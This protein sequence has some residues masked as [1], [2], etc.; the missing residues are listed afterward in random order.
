[1]SSNKMQQWF[2][3]TEAPVIVNAPMAGAVSPELA[4]E[5]SKAGGLGF[6]GCIADVSENSQQ[7]TKLDVDLIKVR[8]LLSS[9]PSSSSS[10]ATTP[11]GHLRIGVGFLTCHP[12]IAHFAATALPIVKK[13]RPAAVWLFAPHERIRPQ[14]EIV[15]LLKGLGTAEGG[16]APRVFVQVGNVAAAREA[17]ADGADAVVCQGTDA[18]GHQFRRGMGVV[19]L[20]GETRRL[21]DEGGYEDVCVLAAGGIADGKGVAAMMTLEADAVVLGTRFTV[22]QE[23]IVPDFRKQIIL[24]ASDGALSTLKSPFN[25]D[26]ADSD[27]WGSLYDGRAVVG[28]I[29]EKFLAGASLDECRRELH[30]EHSPEEA[31]RLIDTWAGAGIGLVRK[32]QPAGEI[33]RELREEAKEAIRKVAARVWA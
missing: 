22:A 6:L 23:S 29:H 28:P 24:E 7:V 4:A 30:E 11:S 18:G 20:L 9:P 13:H 10:S 26:I 5:V 21:V 14:G 27:L 31:A 33:V 32:E 16:E 1:M 2:P 15:R 12:S 3:W 19:P 8:Q 17:I 25:D